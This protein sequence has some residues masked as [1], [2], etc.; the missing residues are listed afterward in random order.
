MI[1][2]PTVAGG[3]PG[4]TIDG[5]FGG[6]GL[7]RLGSPDFLPK[8]QHTNQ[9]EFI[10]TLSW[11]RG[12]HAI[13]FGADI[14]APMKNEYLDVPATRGAM[15]FRECVHRQR[16]WRDF[17]LGYVSDL[18]L[19]NVWVVDQRH[20]ATMCFVQDDWKVSDAADAEPRPAL[21]LHH[22][23]A[24]SGQPADELRSGGDRQP[25]VRAGRLAR[26]P[27]PGEARTQQLRA[28]RRRRLQAGREDDDPRRLR[29]SSTTCS[30]AS[31]ARI[32]S[33]S[34]CRG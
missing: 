12:N 5:Y 10:D 30:I 7:G 8:F 11:L 26:G 33:R 17:L 24:R 13:K 21:R 22:A 18:Q 34:T 15:R 3:F 23:G 4:I 25:G 32:S 29:A 14:I 19:S 28:A 31:A 20:W 16:R 6:S 27:R 1:T 9:F 2:N